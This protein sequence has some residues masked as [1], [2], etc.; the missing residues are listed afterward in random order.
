MANP[1]AAFEDEENLRE[2]LKR[3][4]KIEVIDVRKRPAESEAAKALSLAHRNGWMIAALFLVAS[5]QTHL[6]WRIEAKVSLAP[7]L[8]FLKQ[9]VYCK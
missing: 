6:L 4:S 5:F 7:D 2:D 3:L 1:K 9:N 8:N